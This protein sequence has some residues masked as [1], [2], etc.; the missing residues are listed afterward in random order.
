ME[1]A[2]EGATMTPTPVTDEFLVNTHGVDAPPPAFSGLQSQPTIAALAGGGFVVVWASVGPGGTPVLPG[3][4]FTDIHAQV[5]DAAGNPV[6]IEFR[7]NTTTANQ[8]FSPAVAALDGGGFV[9]TY[10]AH[11]V[12]G[13]AN[14]SVVGQRFDADGDPVGGEFRV[15]QDND[16]DNGQQTSTVTALEGGGFLVTWTAP[17]QDGPT[18]VIDGSGAAVLGRIYDAAGA[19]VTNEF[20][21][22]TTTLNNQNFSSA[23]ALAGGFVVTWSSADPASPAVSN[24]SGQRFDLAGNPVGDEFP[25]N[26]TTAN[27]QSFSS[28]T[29][30]AGG[31]F[32]VTWSSVVAGEYNIIGRRFAGFEA[33]GTPIPAGGEFTI[34][35]FTP[36][37][38]IFS[39]V[40]ALADGGFL[41]VWQSNNQDGGNFGVFGQRFDAAGNPVGD[42]FQ[43]NQTTAGNQGFEQAGGDYTAV[44]LASGEVMVVWQSGSAFGTDVFA[45]RFAL[46]PLSDDVIVVGSSDTFIDLSSHVDVAGDVVV[47]DNPNA[48]DIDLSNLGSVGGD[49]TL[50]NNDALL[51]VS[52][53]NLTEVGGS[54][55]VNDNTVAGGID[56]SALLSSG[57]PVNVNNN[58]VG[59][60][61]DLSALLSSGGPVDVN[62]N[63]VGGGIDLSAL[64]S[65]GG[66]VNVNNNTVAGGIDLSALES[67]GGSVNV[68]DNTMTAFSAGNLGSVGGNFSVINNASLL[69]LNLPSLTEVAGNFD[70][71]DN[72]AIANLNVGSLVEAQ[73]FVRVSN[74]A[75]LETVVAG[76]LGKVGGDLAVTDNPSLTGV[77]LPSLMEVGGNLDVS[78]NPSALQLD[79][80]ALENVGGSVNISDNDA[81]DDINI[82]SLFDTKGG[83]N[84]SNNSSIENVVA[85][86]LNQVGGDFAVI[87]NAS[88]AGL[89][90]PNLAAV[91]GDLTVAGNDAMAGITIL[92]PVTVAGDVELEA[93]AEGTTNFITTGDFNTGGG[94]VTTKVSDGASNTIMIGDTNTGGGDLNAATEGTSGTVT[95]GDVDTGGG[96]VN[97]DTEGTADVTVGTITT[98]EGD[99]T[100]AAGSDATAV[101][102]SGLGADGGEVVLTGGAGGDSKVTVGDMDDG[103]GVLV[104]IGAGGVTVTAEDGLSR[105]TITGTAGDD[106]ATGSATADNTMD[107]GGGNDDLTGGAAED[108]IDGGEGDDTLEAGDGDD[109]VD[110]GEGDDTIV[111]GH[112]GGNDRYRG[113]AGFDRVTYASAAL[114]VFVDLAAGTATGAEIGSDT[115]SEIEAVTG[116]S[117]D[118]RIGGNAANNALDGAAGNDTAFF[119]GRRSDYTIEAIG[120]PNEY[121]ITD[122]RAGAND[123]TDIVTGFELFEFS[124]RTLSEADLLNPPPLFNVID[125]TAR[126]DRLHGTAAADQISGLAGNDVIWAKAGG[127]LVIAGPGNDVVFA[128]GGDDT[129]KA[130]VKDGNDI[131]FGDG[132]SDTF[133]FSETS[134]AATVSLGTTI[135][136]LTL[137]DV[138]YA[139]SK[140]IGHDLLHDFENAIGGS[141]NDNITGNNAANDLR[142]GAGNDT[143]A[144]LR[145]DD[146]LHGDAGNDR[147]TGGRGS[148]WMDG[149]PGSDTFVFPAAQSQAGDTDMIGGFVVG[150]DHLLFQGLAVNQLAELDVNGDAVLDTQLTLND[151]ARVQLAGVNGVNDWH[152]LL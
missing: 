53:P 86:V 78:D 126:N 99:V 17:K 109:E 145:G 123:G 128:D 26:T 14:F 138:G 41:V 81:L 106:T 51:T 124:D 131:Y 47:A 152:V 102:A 116:G 68:N 38:Q 63:T 70:A 139:T 72:D 130:T 25:I 134:A 121:R 33:D 59:G 75:G 143:I 40:T 114:G 142:G 11:N 150:Q 148:D 71:S 100:I 91:D 144:G 96:D 58:T 35:T 57:G 90:L 12:A 31:G 30:L 3:G 69:G 54:V 76:V 122:N 2:W 19:V 125:G 93:G 5:Y 110:G 95:V 136:G 20:L 46:P 27:D 6:G 73:G 10:T 112:G 79:I 16:G 22:N 127:D 55:D 34:N 94:N 66:P 117:G 132:G 13:D 42:E 23:T 104:I 9:V 85:G 108:D 21:L 98:G 113:G 7:V 52:A 1:R 147:L 24:I 44:Q 15:D 48:T 67:T 28:T 64:L 103:G 87:G 120:D 82:G 18:G 49:F 62:N 74:N 97:I 137:N 65:S 101:D 36:G 92:G 146:T 83:I 29:A 80:S 135:F 84:V 43:I 45:R 37:R 60:G 118:D 39:S 8:Q 140:E 111:G 115:L 107:G 133:D 50:S 61:I 77:I 141:G 119:S 88:L 4:S 56:L 129:V 105:L 149:G 89:T 32:V 151:G